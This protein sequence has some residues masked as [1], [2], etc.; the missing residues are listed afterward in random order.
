[1]D[2]CLSK[3]PYC[4]EG[5]QEVVKT[6]TGEMFYRGKLSN[7]FVLVFPNRLYVKG[8][9]GTYRLGPSLKTL[10]REET[11]HGIEQLSDELHVDMSTASVSRLD[12]GT[13]IILDRP[14]G[15]YMQFL[16]EL[17]YHSASG[18]GS[19][20]NKTR[21]FSN[22]QREIRFYN[23]IQEMKSKGRKIPDAWLGLNVCRY[24]VSFRHPAKDFK[25]DSIS[26]KMLYEQDFFNKALNKWKEL[27]FKIGKIPRMK[28]LP[29]IR[30]E[31]VVDL[32]RLAL[33]ALAMNNDLF[34]TVMSEIERRPLTRSQRSRLRT[35]LIDSRTNRRL[36]IP[37][38]RITELDQKI[39]EAARLYQS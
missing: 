25:A 16:G 18:F 37:D 19:G 27:Y 9:I 23:K 35:R 30:L 33:T 13:N 38:T 5:V 7:L 28:V 24:E 22:S 34:Q 36:T 12:F 31:N 8:S 4:L 39:K 10:T 32:Q 15:E 14:F 6:D 1:M 11:A 26:T 3:L 21:S 20:K 2:N 17:P 29:E